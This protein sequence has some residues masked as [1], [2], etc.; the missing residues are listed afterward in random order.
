MWQEEQGELLKEEIEAILSPLY[1]NG[2][3]YSLLK[4]PLSST[5]RGL[6]GGGE[7]FWPLLP[8]IVCDALSGS[9]EHALPAAAALQFLTA[10]GDVL[11]DIEDADSSESMSARY[12]PA[13]ATSVASTLLILAE[14]AI[15]RLEARG[16][17]SSLIV[18]VMSAVNSFYATACAGQHLDLSLSADTAIS[19]EMYLKIA[20]MKSASQVECACHVGALLAKA[21]QE[22]LERFSAFGHNLGMACQIANDVQG[23][24]TESDIVKPK[25]TLPVVYALAQTSGE[26]HSHLEATFGRLSQPLLGFAQIKDILFR[27]G[28]VHYAVVKMEYYKQSAH[29]ILCEARSAGANVVGLEYFLP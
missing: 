16:V 29:E 4:E 3:L 13:I 10:A 2:G 23:I 18:H 8:L 9:Y 22:M 14:G 24:T 27:T 7:C 12:G 1:G 19:E 5:N 11:D 15:T 25:I 6:A 20:G 21:G 17:E 26:T 28:A